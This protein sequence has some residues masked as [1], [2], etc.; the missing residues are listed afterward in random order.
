M[1]GFFPGP[2]VLGSIRRRR[3]N[4]SQLGLVGFP[5]HFLLYE[6]GVLFHLSPWVRAVDRIIHLRAG[7]TP[8]AFGACLCPYVCP[9]PMLFLTNFVNYG[10][11]MCPRCI[12]DNCPGGVFLLTVAGEEST[13]TMVL[14][15]GSRQWGEPNSPLDSTRNL[16]PSLL[17]KPH[18][19]ARLLPGEHETTISSIAWIHC[20]LNLSEY[21][22][23]ACHLSATVPCG[24]FPPSHSYRVTSKDPDVWLFC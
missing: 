3:D 16:R 6:C 9:E 8:E 1:S 19:L 24:Y 10:L 12:C 14:C 20:C 22:G 2:S 17:R 15:A 11:V 7:F 23:L 5:Y 13:E 21:L 4:E 18:R